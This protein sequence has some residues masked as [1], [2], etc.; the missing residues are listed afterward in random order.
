MEQETTSQSLIKEESKVKATRRVTRFWGSLIQRIEKRGF[1][2][3]FK[4]NV[5]YMDENLGN[6]VI[7]ASKT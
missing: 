6:K 5:V 3:V 1:N 4:Q 7:L 2:I